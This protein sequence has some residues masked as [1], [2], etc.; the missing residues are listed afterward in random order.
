MS[1]MLWAALLGSGEAQAAEV[2]WLGSSPSTEDL[3]AVALASGVEG[4]PRTPVA[5]RAA[6]TDKTDDDVARW[7]ALDAALRDVR[8]FETRLDGELVI[9]EE[10][11][12]ALDGL[13]LLPNQDA[14]D[15]LF[16]ALA[17]EGFAVDRFFMDGL[18]EDER[19]E[20]YRVVLTDGT[21][22]P[23]PWMD[24]VG[25]DPE[26]QVTPYEIAEAAQRARFGEV[27]E[28]LSTELPARILIEG[29]LPAGS[30]L[31]VDGVVVDPGTT[32]RVRV[33]PGRHFAHVVLDGHV[34]ART[35]QRLGPN[36][37]LAVAVALDDA[38]FQGWL[39][40]VRDGSVA[41]VPEAIRPSIE[42]WG[43]VVLAWSGGK[44]PEA[45]RVTPSG[46]ER[47]DVAKAARVASG[48]SSSFSDKGPVRQVQVAAAVGGGWFSSGDFYLQDPA[49]VE[50]SKASVNAGALDVAIDVSAQIGLFRASVIGD[51]GVPFGADHIALTGSGSMRVRPDVSLGLGVTW[52]QV[53]GGFLFPY[54]PSV[55]ARATIPVFKGLEI[56]G[57]FRA[58]LPVTLQRGGGD[59]AW[60]GLPVYQAWAGIGYRFG[61]DVGR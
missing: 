37:T 2:V 42:A 54:H 19:G 58:G 7:T 1:L 41:D 33:R 17:Y 29:S 9:M 3:A 49:N 47:L 34:L 31:V 26:R 24:A 15:R 13:T 11:G 22:V 6:A 45:A 57:A 46:V 25:L 4:Q 18:G 8:A 38:T 10:L 14:R 61:V 40:G 52:V 56:V 27:R 51:L 28:A 30:E 48:A 59:E 20:G 50:R 21:V 44:G 60:T 55:G 12:L 16:A 43:E 39:D 36:D 35:Q 23:R 32:G 53:T 5:L